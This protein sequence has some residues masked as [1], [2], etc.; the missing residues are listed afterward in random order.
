MIGRLLC[1]FIE[2]SRN[3]PPDSPDLFGEPDV[4]RGRYGDAVGLGCGDGISYSSISP[5]GVI[6]P[7]RLPFCSVNHT[8]PSVPAVTPYGPE[9]AL[10]EISYSLIVVF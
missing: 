3:Q 2:T 10:S 4:A 9:S 5:S 1:S 8:F 6:R 7:I